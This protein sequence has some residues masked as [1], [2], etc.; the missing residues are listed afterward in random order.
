MNNLNIEIPSPVLG[1]IR[2]LEKAVAPRYTL[3]LAGGFLRDTYGYRSI[4]DIDILVAPVDP[5]DTDTFHTSNVGDLIDAYDIPDLFSIESYVDGSYVANMGDRGVDGIVM[6]SS[7]ALDI[8]VQLIVYDTPKTRVQLAHDMDINICQIVMSP[9][10][11]LYASPAF[12]SG[13]KNKEIVTIN[14]RDAVLD[15]ERRERMSKKY[16]EFSVVSPTNTTVSVL[17]KTEPDCLETYE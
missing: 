12:L 10:G 7:K 5:T 4:K 9:S 1:L 13:F 15:L 3:T 6:G 8:D 11:S 17:S 16:P 2:T 14:P